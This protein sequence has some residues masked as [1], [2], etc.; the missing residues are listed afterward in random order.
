MA[1]PTGALLD[2]AVTPTAADLADAC[3][4][5]ARE[6]W[7]RLSD[8]VERTYGIVGEPLFFGRDSGWVLRFRR[9]GKALFTL[10]PLADGDV[11]AL[12]VAGPSTWAAV[13]D[14][15]LGEPLR[16]AWSTAHPY[17][18]GRW[19]WPLVSDDSVVED[20]ER[21]VALKSPPPRRP[22]VTRARRSN[23]VA[24]PG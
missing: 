5:A 18:D 4:P 21:L 7:V 1:D 17:P 23:P 12:V 10:L 2:R 13:A 9:S 22:G 11:R 20:I 19:L 16:A 24:A 8:W 6:R 15:Q 14:T 3:G